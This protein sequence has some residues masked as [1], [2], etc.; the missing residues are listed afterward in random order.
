MHVTRYPDLDCDP[1]MGRSVYP[2]VEGSKWR[3]GF[4]PNIW[5]SSLVK[6][7]VEQ[8]LRILSVRD[9]SLLAEP[10][11]PHISRSVAFTTVTGRCDS[12]T[13]SADNSTTPHLGQP[14]LFQNR[15]L[16]SAETSAVIVAIRSI[17]R[18]H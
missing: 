13:F 10:H 7:V 9:F 12:K 16:A 2:K 18:R 17:K 1:D 15:R 14:Q 5:H 6:S 11:L 3:N 4:L 8:A